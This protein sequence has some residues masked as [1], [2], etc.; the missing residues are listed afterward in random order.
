[1]GIAFT[2]QVQRSG[3]VGREPASQRALGPLAL[4]PWRLA[5]VAVMLGLDVGPV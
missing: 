5:M 3:V 2:N 1:M 4:G